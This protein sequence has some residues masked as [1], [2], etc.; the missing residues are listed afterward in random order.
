[1]SLEAR[2][3]LVM[4]GPVGQRNSTKKLNKPFQNLTKAALVEELNARGI[5]EGEKKKDLEGLLKESLHG[6][7]RVPALLYH[8]PTGS[9]SSINCHNYEI[10]GFE[11][12]HD[13]GKHIENV[14]TE[15]PF[16]LPK[17]QCEEFQSITQTYLG[18]K[19]TKRMVDYRCLIIILANRMRS[20]L[21]KDAQLLLDTL[22]KIQEA[23]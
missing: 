9:L 13:V 7:Q 22:V 1:M 12:M 21:P 20:M 4:K 16:H 11:P 23:A 10:L 17:P 6:I 19:E 2:Q 3:R 8:N 18:N 5:Y 15:M 14:I